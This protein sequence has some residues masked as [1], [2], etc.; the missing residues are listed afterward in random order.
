MYL[1]TKFQLIWR[2]SDFVTK[3]AQ[4]NMNEKNFEKI[5]FKIVGMYPST[6]FQLIWR[7]SDFGNKIFQK[8]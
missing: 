3:F 6:E 4:K 5:K 7:T 1:C 2:T 8:I